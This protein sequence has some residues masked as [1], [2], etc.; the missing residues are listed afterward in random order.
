MLYSL[1]YFPFLQSVMTAKDN[2]ESRNRTNTPDI[3]IVGIIIQYSKS[4]TGPVHFEWKI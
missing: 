2:Y 3:F 4:V 1:L